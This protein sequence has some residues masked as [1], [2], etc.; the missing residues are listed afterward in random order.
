M[1]LDAKDRIS[2]NPEDLANIDYLWIT[3]LFLLV[4]VVLLLTSKFK[5]YPNVMQI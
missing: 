1:E 2:R 3:Y 5:C 4:V